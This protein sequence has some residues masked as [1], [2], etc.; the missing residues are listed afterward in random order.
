VAKE[1]V[2]ITVK[3][4]PTLSS[5]YDEVVCTAGLREDGTWVRIYPIPFR[6]LDDYEQYRKFDWIEVDLER[7][8]K[9]PRP[10]SHRLNSNIKVLRHVDTGHDWR[11]RRDL[12]LSKS[13]VYTNFAEII[14]RNK[15][16]REL[17]LATFKPTEIVDF[18]FEEDEREWDQDKLLTIEAKAQQ[19][20]LFQDNSRC[21]KVVKK[22]PYKFR[23]R[24]KDDTGKE[25]KMMIS[26]WEIGA[27]Y[28]NEL[29]RHG[30]NEKKTL[31]SV[32]T[33]YL[34]QL[35]ENRDTHLFVGTSQRWDSLNAPNPFIIVG[36]FSPPIALQ[37]E[38]F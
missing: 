26:D 18:T 12:V 4:Y 10:E 32:R 13:N 34:H 3:T 1:K 7:N 16:D 25:R 8:L 2:L 36:V 11:E 5:K 15:E 22:L 35:V 27:L 31:E 38:L 6:K 19:N 21:F 9:D 30:G 37:K 17:S 29:K 14:E 28:W 24:F 20:D 33:K 23:Y